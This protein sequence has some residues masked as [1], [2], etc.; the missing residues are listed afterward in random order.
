[1]VIKGKFDWYSPEKTMSERAQN[2][3]NRLPA[4]NS[5]PHIPT[6]VMELQQLVQQDSATSAQIAQ[7]SKKDP[8]IAGNIL[9]IANS[10]KQSSGDIVIESLEHAVSYVGINALKDIILA[11][12]IQAFPFET[13]V[14]NADKFWEASFLTG[15]IAEKLAEKYGSNSIIPDEAYLAGAL[16]NVGKV[17]LAIC[18]PQSADTIAK[19]EAD[20]KVLSNWIKGERKH[21]IPSHQILGEIGAG[22]WGLPSYITVCTGNHHARPEPGGLNEVELSDIIC[23]ANQMSHWVNLEP[24]K[25]D[26]SLLSAVASKFDLNEES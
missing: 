10:M 18:F 22:L 4:L 26:Q 20:P 16:C 25:I 13:S 24:H 15:R 14:F 19:D 21:D 9:K 5:L 6:I 3:F 8:L 12:S 1:M 7:L 17:V 23:L 2:I 11:A